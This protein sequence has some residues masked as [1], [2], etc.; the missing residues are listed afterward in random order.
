[1]VNRRRFLQ[2]TGGSAVLLLSGAAGPLV[3]CTMGAKEVIERLRMQ[4]YIG[5]NTIE[6]LKIDKGYL[7]ENG[8]L[9]LF[10]DHWVITDGCLLKFSLIDPYGNVVGDC[11]A[12]HY[13]NKG[14]IMSLRW[15]LGLSFS[16]YDRDV[17]WSYTGEIPKFEKWSEHRVEN[18]DL[19]K[20]F[21][22]GQ[23]SR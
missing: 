10:S 16:K 13:L 21:P 14:D 18:P 8:S 9:E 1:M 3:P 15:H 20:Y 22:M 17:L 6:V 12:Q 19:G 23:T 4:V 2:F 11:M 5:S 7:Y